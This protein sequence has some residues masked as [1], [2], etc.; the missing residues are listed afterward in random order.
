MRCSA[1]LSAVLLGCASQPRATPYVNPH[2]AEPIGSVREMYDGRLTPELA[3]TTFRNIDRLF[4]TRIIARGPTVSPLPTAAT[5]LPPVTCSSRSVMASLD[6]YMRLNRVSGLLVLKNGA[7]VLERYALGATRQTRWMSM[8]VA[9]SITS[10][11]IGIAIAEGRIASIDDPVTRYVARL[12]GSAY[13]G[14]SVRQVLMMASGVRWNETYTDP[15]SDRRRLLDAQIAQTPGAALTLMASLPRAAPPG[16]VFTYST[17]ETLIAGEI[18]RGAVGMSTSEY[19][20]AKIWKPLGMEAD[21]AWWLDSPDGHE[22]AG[23]GISATLRDYARFGQFFMTGGMVNG[24][25]ILPE[26]WVAEA[27]SPKVLA[28][29]KRERY[30]YM[31]WPIDAAPGSA[32][33]DAFSA[34]GIFGQAIYIN[35]REQVVIVQSA[36]Q[37]HPTAGEVM[38]PDDCFA[39]VVGA[40]RGR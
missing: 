10:T 2:A 6:E 36:A 9:K 16:S 11:L 15:T 12:T 4:P 39:A 7:L 33:A 13:D 3:A 32:N 27:G 25:R 34:Q 37:T 14:V 23:S 19:L 29:G 26:G 22:I 1:L 17:G 24:R 38:N 28:G 21:A 35:P 31:W 5:P 30:G 18:V 40:L 20:S 8:S